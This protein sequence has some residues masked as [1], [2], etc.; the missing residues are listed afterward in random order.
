VPGAITYTVWYPAIQPHE[1]RF[2]VVGVAFFILTVPGASEPQPAIKQRYDR[3]GDPSPLII[4]DADT[5]IVDPTGLPL[6]G[7]LHRYPERWD[8][9]QQMVAAKEFRNAMGDRD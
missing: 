6:W 3:P 1:R 4:L 9:I 8:R 7:T 5:F 2:E